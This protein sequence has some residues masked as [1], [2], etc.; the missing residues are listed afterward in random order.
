MSV[1]DVKK[2]YER[3]ALNKL[4]PSQV[5]KIVLNHAKE[6]LELVL[7]APNK[8]SA[9]PEKRKEYKPPGVRKL[10]PEQAKLLLIGH[11]SVGNE[12]AKDILGLLFREPE[13]SSNADS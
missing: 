5:K 1:A 9:E 12:G 10:T 8:P 2:A 13:E 11:A 7:G 3:P 6:F 4:S